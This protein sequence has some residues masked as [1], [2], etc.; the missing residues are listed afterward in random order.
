MAKKTL[1]ALA[2]ES[3][4]PVAA[5]VEYKS[6]RDFGYAVAGKSD[7]VRA[8][9]A[10]ALDNIQGVPEE[11]SSETKSELYEGFRQRY[12]ERNPE[13]E[14]AV[15]DG[16]YLPVSQ[17][18]P[19]AKTIERLHIGVIHAFSYT[20]QAFGA[21]KETDL[22]KYNLL[23]DIRDKVNKYCWNCLADLKAAARKVLKQRNPESSTR[24]ATDA[25]NVAA[26]KMLTKMKERVKTAAA[27]GDVSADAK[28]LD[29]AIIAFKVKYETIT[30]YTVSEN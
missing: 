27:R 22:N 13:T 6:I 12:S 2:V 4:L 7:A 5:A 9:G 24:A 1:V 21:L 8:D 3:T 15:I 30:G 14:Y 11:I 19:D 25:F 16:N 17:L 18:S 10:W 28:A 20:Q 26:A 29:A 23:K